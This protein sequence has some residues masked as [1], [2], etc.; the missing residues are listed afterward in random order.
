MDAPSATDP[1]GAT[2][3]PAPKRSKEHWVVLG[4]AGALLLLLLGLALFVDADP[5][6]FGTHEKLGMSPC[7]TMEWW[8][9]PCPGCGVTTSVTLATKGRIVESFVNQ[10]FGLLTALL[11]LGAIVWAPIA[12]LR[13]RD[14]W[15][16]VQALR[17]G[18][19]A[20]AL[21]AVIVAAWAYKFWR[22]RDGG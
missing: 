2:P 19:W 12:H 16:D 20:W 1:I 8:N 5:R 6:G 22:V 10:P 17:M 9:V 18:W 15:R 11:F 21:G 14:L 13:G 7:A 3:A 4:G